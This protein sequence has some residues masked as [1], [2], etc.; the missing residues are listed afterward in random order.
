MSALRHTITPVAGSADTKNSMIRKPI[1]S[2][3]EHSEARRIR[4]GD[5]IP[6][7]ILSI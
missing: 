5:F 7:Y 6:Q 1:I 2:F 3:Q 4:Y